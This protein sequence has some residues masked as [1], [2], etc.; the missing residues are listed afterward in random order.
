MEELNLPPHV[1]E[2]L[3]KRYARKLQQQAADGCRSERK[4][5]SWEGP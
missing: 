1:I 2:T 5:N 4:T 3:E